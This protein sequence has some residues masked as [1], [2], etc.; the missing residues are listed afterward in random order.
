MRKSLFVVAA[1]MALAGGIASAAP[2]LADH[3]PAEQQSPC[4]PNAP[5]G[6]EVVGYADAD[7]QRDLPTIYFNATDPQGAY[8]GACGG[9]SAGEPIRYVEVRMTPG[10]PY[11]YGSDG[12]NGPVDVGRCVLVFEDFD[13][14]NNDI[15]LCASA[16]VT[17]SRTEASVYQYREYD[18]ILWEAVGVS[19]SQ[20]GVEVFDIRDDCNFNCGRGKV[21]FVRRSPDGRV[22]VGDREYSEEMDYCSER[23]YVVNLADPASSG[24]FSYG[25]C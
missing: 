13:Y 1:A 22:V 24:A 23:G 6:E 25:A 21:Y 14:E 8:I 4:R 20:N 19:A 17:G 3:L 10:G 9:G 5:A 16:A 15:Y 18:G 2:S 11:V 12:A 7:V